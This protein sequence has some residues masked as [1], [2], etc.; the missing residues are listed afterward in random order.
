MGLAKELRQ[1]RE[2]RVR[3]VTVPAWGDKDGDF[4]LYCKP[5]TCRDLDIL[6]KKH[7]KFLEN[8]TISGMVDLIVLK[9]LDESGSKLFKA[10]DDAFELM[11]EQTDVITDIASQMFDCLLYTSDAADD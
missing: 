8:T 9:A 10:G 11:K 6:Q 3:E 4:K 2:V 5:I 7:P 1:R